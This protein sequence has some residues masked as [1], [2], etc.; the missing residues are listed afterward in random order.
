VILRISAYYDDL[1]LYARLLETGKPRLLSGEKVS[2]FLEKLIS[3]KISVFG[4]PETP[5]LIGL[6]TDTK[7]VFSR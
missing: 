1:G 4:R 3:K 7:S 5:N 6:K 2:V